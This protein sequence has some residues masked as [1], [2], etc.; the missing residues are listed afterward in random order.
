MPISGRRVLDQKIHD[1]LCHGVVRTPPVEIQPASVSVCSLVSSR[2]F[3]MYLVAIKSFYAQL[4]QGNVYAINDGSLTKGQERLLQQQVR[5]ITLVHIQDAPQKRVP[6]GGCWERLLYMIELARSS[7]VIQL[8]SDTLTRRPLA[9]VID[10]CV[11]QTPFIISGDAAGSRIVTR[12]EAAQAVAS[13]QSNH[14][15]TVM[16]Q[17]LATIEGLKP[18]YVRGCAAFF[19]LP[20]GAISF[21]EVEEFSESMQRALGERWKEWGTEQAAVNYLLANLAGTSVLQPPK[22]AHR[23]ES[24]PSD[25]TAFIHFIGTH[26]FDGQYYALQSRK[27]MKT[28]RYPLFKPGSLGA[29]PKG[30]PLRSG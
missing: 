27:V 7:Y 22:Y 21:D 13:A 11:G 25:E 2:D 28:L 9:E 19:G 26:R 1:L 16:E 17:R 3:Y 6:K 24:L 10:A 15:Q 12:Q 4:G 18:F 30:I 20:R 8:D 23:W 29:T 5:G 14:V